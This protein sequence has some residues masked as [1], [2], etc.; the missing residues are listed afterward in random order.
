MQFKN[1][2]NYVIKRS[3]RNKQYDTNGR[4]TQVAE[5]KEKSIGKSLFPY[6]MGKL[7]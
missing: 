5:T 1:Q 7:K 4:G 3:K 6:F 2:V